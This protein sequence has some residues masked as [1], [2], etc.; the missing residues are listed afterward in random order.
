MRRRG[1]R[2]L[3]TDRGWRRAAKLLKFMTVKRIGFERKKFEGGWELGSRNGFVFQRS[4]TFPLNG[5]NIRGEEEIG[6]AIAY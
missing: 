5:L 3:A 1:M 4:G 6:C 2:G